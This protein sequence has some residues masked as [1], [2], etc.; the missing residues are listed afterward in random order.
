MDHIS[1]DKRGADH[2]HTTRCHYPWSDRYQAG[3]IRYTQGSDVTYHPIC[4]GDAG[5]EGQE[6]QRPFDFPF[7]HVHSHPD[8]I[9]LADA[10]L[11]RPHE[12]IVH[13]MRSS[14]DLSW[15]IRRITVEAPRREAQGVALCGQNRPSKR[16]AATRV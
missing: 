9:R 1:E 15:S 4:D 12:L 14:K 2:Q 13:V 8:W 11:P 5:H 16:R 6:E 10:L 3:T 7:V